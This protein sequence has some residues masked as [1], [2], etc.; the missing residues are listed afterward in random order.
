MSDGKFLKFDEA[1]N[2]K[3]ASALKSTKKTDHL[4]VT[5]DGERKGEC[6]ESHPPAGGAPRLAQTRESR[7]RQPSAGHP[8]GHVVGCQGL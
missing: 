2:A 6:R 1:G 8:G 7:T 3:I 4:R 5:V